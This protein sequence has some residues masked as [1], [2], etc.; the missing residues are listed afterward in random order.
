MRYLYPASVWLYKMHFPIPLMTFTEVGLHHMTSQE[1][2][3]TY[4][5]EDTQAGVF[6]CST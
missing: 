6:F 4:I 3:R 2:G 5:Q 1:Q